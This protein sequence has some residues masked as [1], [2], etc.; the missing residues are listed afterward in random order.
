MKRN[1]ITLVLATWV[2]ALAQPAAADTLI[3]AGR[4]IDGT[5]NQP[6][7]NVTIRIAENKITAIE[8]GFSRGTD[9]D[10]VIDMRN[11]TVMPGFIDMH[12]H[13]TSQSEPGSYMHRFTH[14][15]A[16][17]AFRAAHFADL[18]LRAGFTTVRDLGDSFAASVALKRAIQAGYVHGPR[19]YT[20]AK[21]LA[22]TGGHADPSN[23]SRQGLIENPGPMEG[24]VNGVD[25]ARQAVR[26]R[27]Q[28]GADLIKITATGG[29]LSMA[30]SGD[31]PQFMNDELAAIVET[32][33][34]YGMRVAVHAHGKDGMARAIRAGVDSIEHGTYMDDEIFALMKEHGT[35][36]VPTITA[37]RSVAERAEIDGYFPEQVRSKARAIGPLIQGTFGRAYA[38]GVN[39]AFGTDSGVYD[40]GENAREFEYMVEAGMPPIE[41]IR[42]AT[43]T[44]ATLLGAEEIIG[45]IEVGKYAD[46]VAIRGNPLSDITLLKDIHLVIKDG[47]I[48]VQP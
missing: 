48:Y 14:N 27:Y 13:L 33:R 16:D 32:A 47:V 29:V 22:T 5:A 4:L 45:S 34:D 26:A 39:I 40:H 36:Y 9:E 7:E 44:A 18:T 6:K 25:D 28:E 42:A 3:H 17:V 8:S 35:Y 2:C 10:V 12:T 43:L 19:V 21:S 20:A 37:G 23:G 1:V 15:E 11:G 30:A 41:A 24:V 31:N 38:A 46:I